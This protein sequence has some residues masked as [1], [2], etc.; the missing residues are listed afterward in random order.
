VAAE[1]VPSLDQAFGGQ[2]PDA[3]AQDLWQRMIT[4]HPL[5]MGL[6]FL[7]LGLVFLLYGYKLYKILV[8]VVFA[9][10]GGIGGVVLGA[11]LGAPGWLL[12]LIGAIVLGILAWP[13]FRIG[14]GILGGAVFAAIA[15]PMAVAMTNSPVLGYTLAGVAFIA[16]MVLTIM[17]MRPLIIIS[18]S[19]SGAATLVEGVLLMLI[20]WPSAGDPIRAELESKPY[21][22]VVLVALPAVLG[23]VLQWRDTSGTR[24]AAKKSGRKADDDGDE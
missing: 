14:W 3:I 18:T 23:A 11:Y 17:L 13:L 8:S 4:Q 16:G 6:V 5:E 9:G 1:T 10:V 2:S 22:F 21:L 12:G 15:L 7:V 24:P 20:R 19:I